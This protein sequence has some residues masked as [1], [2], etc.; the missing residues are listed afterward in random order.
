[1]A[2]SSKGLHELRQLHQLE[3]AEQH[4]V[5]RM[6]QKVKNGALGDTVKGVVKNPKGQVKMSKVLEKFI[7]PYLETTKTI[8]D[9]EVLVEL[10]VIAW[11][12]ALAPEGDRQ[13]A[14]NDL[15]KDASDF[16]DILMQREA[17]ALIQEMI[18]RKE[19]HF[20]NIQRFIVDFELQETGSHFNLVVVSTTPPPPMTE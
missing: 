4:M 1:M 16:Q 12:L 13:Q 2:R 15:F 9:R 7:D 3:Q 6:Q 18:E 5:D 10:A 20:A 8:A 14:M 17:K 11:N 19:K